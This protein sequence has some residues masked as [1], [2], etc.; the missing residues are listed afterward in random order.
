[1]AEDANLPVTGWG[2]EVE[3]G[4]DAVVP[5]TGVTLDTGLLRQDIVILPLE[6]ANNLREAVKDG[7]LAVDPF[8]RFRYI[9]T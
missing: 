6:K 2:D 5:E 8:L 9:N 4:M 1:M 3:H 7:R